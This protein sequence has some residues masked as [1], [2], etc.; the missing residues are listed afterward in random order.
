MSTPLFLLLGLTIAT[1]VIAYWSDNLGKKLGKKR[2]SLFGLRPRQTATLMTM[3]SSVVIMFFTLGVLLATN[4]GLRGALLRYDKERADNRDLRQKNSALRTEQ[5][6]LQSE[7]GSAQKQAAGAKKQASDAQKQASSFKTQ[8]FEAHNNY[9]SALGLLKG[10]KAQ[11]RVAKSAERAAHSRENA[12]R[13]GEYAAK[14]SARKVGLEL[15]NKKKELSTVNLDLATARTNLDTL[16]A[17][18]SKAQESVI[19]TQAKL[20]DEQNKVAMQQNDFERVAQASQKLQAELVRQINQLQ[21]NIEDFRTQKVSLEQD[22]NELNSRIIRLKLLQTQLSQPSAETIDVVKGAVYADALIPPHTNASDTTEKLRAMLN[23]GREELAR[24]NE[25]RTIKLLLK[26]GEELPQEVIIKS[27]AQF[28]QSLDTPAS[29]RLSAYRFH[30]REETEIQCFFVVVQSRIAFVRDEVMAS[31]IID[32]SQSDARI[33]NQLLHDLLDA[34]E[35]E[36]NKKGVVPILKRG[37]KIYADGTNERLFEVLRRVQA[38][39]KPVEVRL[40]ADANLT[41]IEPLRVHFEVGKPD[42]N[43]TVSSPDSL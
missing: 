31:K 20:K 10:Q 27:L 8:A 36:A 30:A 38:I 40:V 24:N 41:T 34:G 21:Q 13:A 5:K 14:A 16:Q 33:F 29:V 7:V 15:A 3:T 11:L 39:G 28:L 6:N 9:Q 37:E 19:Q 22:I 26:T 2:V 42:S 1:C 17:Q 12:A 43:K 25:K 32:G 23:E 18:L 35:S 4:S